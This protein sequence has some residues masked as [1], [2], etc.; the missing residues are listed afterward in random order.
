MLLK[1][2]APQTL[3]EWMEIVKEF[4][5]QPIF[6]ET[7]HATYSVYYFHKYT[8]KKAE[9]QFFTKLKLI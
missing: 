7:S 9:K 5:T 3:S 6:F 1:V 4:D 2:F 8:T